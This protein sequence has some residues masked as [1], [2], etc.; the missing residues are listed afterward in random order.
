VIDLSDVIV[1][2][3]RGEGLLAELR[4]QGAEFVARGVYFKHLLENLKSK[5]ERP[6]QR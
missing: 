3:K 1:I 2:D 5:E 4:E 6:F